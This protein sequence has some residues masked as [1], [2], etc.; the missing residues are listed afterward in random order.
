MTINTTKI[1]TKEKFQELIDS[2]NTILIYFELA[3]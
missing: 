1:K 3:G 2:N